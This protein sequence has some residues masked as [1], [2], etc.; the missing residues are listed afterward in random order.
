MVIPVDLW[1]N[2]PSLR[3][4]WSSGAKVLCAISSPTI[5]L[6]TSLLSIYISSTTIQL[7]TSLLPIYISSTTIQ[8]PTSLLPIYISSTT[9]QL[10]YIPPSYTLVVLLYSLPSSLLPIYM[11]ML[12]MCR[13]IRR[14]AESHRVYGQ[15][16]KGRLLC[17]CVRACVGACVGVYVCVCVCVHVYG[18]WYLPL[19]RT[20]WLCQPSDAKPTQGPWCTWSAT[21][22]ENLR[23]CRRTSASC[24]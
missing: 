12:C 4:S 19:R 9:I 14:S 8:L 6:P 24:R 20:S 22:W 1:H 13:C 3:V 15:Y 5:Q 7:P 23:L 21:T 16:T 2:V 11:C 18:V 10:A 17:V